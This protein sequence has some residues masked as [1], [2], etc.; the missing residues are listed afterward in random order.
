MPIDIFLTPTGWECFGKARQSYDEFR[1]YSAHKALKVV[2][3]LRLNSCMPERR[4]FSRLFPYRFQSY[5]KKIISTRFLRYNIFT[6]QIISYIPYNSCCTTYFSVPDPLSIAFNK[7]SACRGRHLQEIYIE[8][9]GNDSPLCHGMH[10]APV[11]F[12]LQE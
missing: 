11:I 1:V 5:N 6:I 4:S 7:G 10:L 9:L 3:H 2:N 8:R 12:P